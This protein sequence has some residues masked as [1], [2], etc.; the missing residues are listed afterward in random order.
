MIPYKNIQIEENRAVLIRSFTMLFMYDFGQRSL[1]AH[2]VA[3]ELEAGTL[4]LIP[5]QR[6]SLAELSR[7]YIL[8]ILSSHPPSHLVPACLSCFVW[9]V[10]DYLPFYG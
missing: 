2:I 1:P 4:V 10:D 5:L 6:L 3:Q 7:F 9:L 8:S